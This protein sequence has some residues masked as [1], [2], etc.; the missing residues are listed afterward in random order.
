MDMST[1]TW[2]PKCFCF[3]RMTLHRHGLVAARVRVALGVGG[4]ARPSAVGGGGDG[5]GPRPSAVGG[6]RDGGQRRRASLGGGGGDGGAA[7]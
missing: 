5:G 4:G 3:L 1:Y 7:A 2:R 6:G